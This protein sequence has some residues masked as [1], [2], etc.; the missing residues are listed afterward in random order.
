M[1]KHYGRSCA[2]LIAQLIAAGGHVPGFDACLTHLSVF[3]FYLFGN[4]YI[5]Q[6]QPFWYFISLVSF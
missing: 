4:F 1:K 3:E 2:C 6:I 5:F